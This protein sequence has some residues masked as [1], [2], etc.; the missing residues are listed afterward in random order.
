MTGDAI[1]ALNDLAQ[2]FLGQ[3][4]ANA[5]KAFMVNKALGISQAVVNTAQA[6]TAALTAGGNPIKLATGAQFVEA[7]IAAAAGA[8]QV[9]TIAAQ[10]FNAGGGGGGSV[11]TNIPTPSAMTSTPRTPSFNVVGQSG[12][13][14][15][16]ESL[17]SKPMKAYVVG[18]EVSTQQQLDRKKVQTSSIG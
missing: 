18:G 14:A 9:A 17:Q 2:A 16:L 7:G 12:T 1:G 3:N 15:L 11:D 10:Q 13:N 4:E 5:R 6:V 8:A